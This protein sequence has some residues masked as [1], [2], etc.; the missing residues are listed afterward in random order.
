MSVDPLDQP[1]GTL[2]EVVGRHARVAGAA[3]ALIA[4][5]RR[6]TYA[7]LDVLADRVAVSLWR[8]G[9][10]PGDAVAI[11]AA[12]S[13]EFVAAYVGALRIG[14]MV[15][16]LPTMVSPESLRTMAVDSS[17][18]LL[19]ADES[20]GTALSGEG[21]AAGIPRIMLD[22]SPAGQS[23]RGWLAPD[24]SRPPVVSRAPEAPCN[25]IYSSGTTSAPK[26]VLQSYAMRWAHMRYGAMLG[27]GGVMMISTPLYA[28]GGSV[29]LLMALGAGATAV[30]MGR[31]DAAKFLTLAE[32]YRATH[33]TLVPVQY[34]RILARPDFDGHDLSSFRL[35]LSVGAA[36]SAPLKAEILRRW[37]G[38]LAE[39]YGM[40]EG[41][42]GCMLIAHEHP[43]KLHTV[44]RPGQ[45][46]DL[47]VI[48]DDGNEVPAGEAGEVVGR[49]PIM[50]SGYHNRPDQTAEA[51][52]LDKH[53]NRFIRSGDIGRFDEDGFLTIVDR[54]KDMINSGGF[55]IYSRDLEEALLADGQVQ[56]AAV[57]GA[58]SERWG[59]TPVAFVVAKPGCQL[60]PEALRKAANAMLGKP[61]RLSRVLVVDELP[62]NAVGK[63]LKRELRARLTETGPL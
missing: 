24:G 52:W 53:G 47:R 1:F 21:P 31:F 9:L 60:D 17:A 50:M 61:Q 45:N 48:D 26:G 42:G 18:A 8:D 62:R 35:T 10:R 4:D 54:K 14:V 22:G 5:D 7:E 16:L 13:I 27:G 25:I 32:R 12:N 46:N 58:P 34:Q 55:N 11:C 28:T 57:V 29:S 36:S 49:S 3:T 37:P 59:E 44:G 30:L 2:P 63:L 15:A 33:A 20:P 51:E 40:T 19:F 38:G 39:I 41:G 23:L 6:L 43:D 56:E